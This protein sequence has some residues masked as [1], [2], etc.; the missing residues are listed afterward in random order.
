MSELKR[1]VINHIGT[2]YQ[3]WDQAGWQRVDDFNEAMIKGYESPSQR[4]VV[5]R[6]QE[7]D[8]AEAL[9]DAMDGGLQRP[10]FFFCATVVRGNVN[11]DDLAA[12]MGYLGGLGLG[13]RRGRSNSLGSRERSASGGGVGELSGVHGGS[14]GNPHNHPQG[15]SDQSEREAAAGGGAAAT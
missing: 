6:R 11:P 7:K 15:F 2:Q 8:S 1:E 3:H 13:P 9:A 10:P 12:G 14:G 4:I 5:C